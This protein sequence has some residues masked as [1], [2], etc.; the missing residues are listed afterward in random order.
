M[1]PLI[2]AHRGDSAHR[3]E[4][5]LASFASAL[6]VG[7]DLVELDVQLTRDGHPVVIHDPTVDR[8][9]DGQGKVV[10]FTLPELRRLSA[11]YPGRFGAA[12]AGERVPTLAQV[13]NF[14]RGR[15]KV[16]I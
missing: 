13:L 5:T 4:N 3:P 11:G 15:C 9:T 10:D 8:T 7:A 6:E 2:I 1:P 12:Y 14:L 16:M